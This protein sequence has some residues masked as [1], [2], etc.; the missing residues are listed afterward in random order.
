MT[1]QIIDKYLKES[2]SVADIEDYLMDELAGETMSKKEVFNTLV[3]FIR[4]K[5][6]EFETAWKNLMQDGDIR[7]IDAK[8]Y[9]IG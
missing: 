4:A 2:A 1:Q 8:R 7:K 3:G 5:K 6:Y 9:K